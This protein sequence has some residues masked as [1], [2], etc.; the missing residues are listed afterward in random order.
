M[1]FPTGL[2]LLEHVNEL[3]IEVA[4][5]SPFLRRLGE[6]VKSAQPIT[7]GA[8]I[9]ASGSV[10]PLA[11]RGV[12]SFMHDVLASYYVECFLQRPTLCLYYRDAN[13]QLTNL[14]R[15]YL[16]WPEEAV[17]SID[18]CVNFKARDRSE[19]LEAAQHLRDLFKT[20]FTRYQ[21]LHSLSH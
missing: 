3:A 6:A 1:R 11:T 7:N 2:V 14:P 18:L 21:R 12:D 8:S 4:R 19:L 10:Q 13:G 9:K 15:S 5:S 20:R 17:A 16:D